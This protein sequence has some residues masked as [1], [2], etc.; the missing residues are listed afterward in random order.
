MNTTV[1]QFYNKLNEKHP[2]FNDGKALQNPDAVMQLY[3]S[4][5]NAIADILVYFFQ[6]GECKFSQ[7][8]FLDIVK[9]P[10][11]SNG[12]V[13]EALVYSWFYEN[14]IDFVPQ[15]KID[16]ENCLKKNN[17]NADGKINKAIFDIK[18]FGLGIPHI[19][20][21][22]DKIQEKMP[23][24][25]VSIG[26]S[27]NISSKD[28]EN[29]AL[30]HID[31]IVEKLKSDKTKIHTDHLYTI[32]SLNLDIRITPKSSTMITSISEFDAYEWAEKNETYFLQHG[33]QFCTNNPYIIFCP[34]DKTTNFTFAS[35]DVGTV[36]LWLRP[37]CRRIFMNLN[38][39]DHKMLCDYDGKAKAGVSIA[40]ASKKISAIVFLDV[41]EQ[42][43]YSDCRI[44][45]FVNPNA[46]NKLYN[47]E[48]NS[49]F[50]LAGAI[51]DDFSFDNY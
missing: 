44:W 34:F 35:S 30:T 26:G 42:H 10:T 50:R 21:L 8:L 22:K 33:S 17:Y 12:K 24:Y 11:S 47:H 46:D 37:L 3:D 14:K 13:Y 29:H 25:I 48:I 27:E 31:D 36:H 6:H 41:T 23:E 39:M 4:Q 9:N 38:R 1:Q 5:V 43:D 51:I 2:N 49:W 45:A 18:Q 32:E 15:P 16:S 40:S 20:T 28:I 19:K 7:E